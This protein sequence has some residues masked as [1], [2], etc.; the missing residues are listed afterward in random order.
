MDSLNSL[1][2]FVVSADTRS[3]AA[4]GRH[5]GISSSAVGKAIARLELRVSVR[6]FHRTTRS[7]TLTPEG[8]TLLE[9]CRRIFGEV[10]AAER[11][12]AQSVGA[13]RGRLRLS[14]P[15]VGRLLVP[16]LTEFAQKYPQ[17]ELELDFSDRVVD[18][19]DEGFDA[20]VRIGDARDSLLMTR[21]LGTFGHHVVAAPTYLEQH[22]LPASIDDLQNHRCLHHKFETTGKLAPWRFIVD[23]VE[24]QPELPRTI[25]ANTVEPLVHLAE[26]GLGL[27]YLPSYLIGSS[28]DTGRLVSVFDE[29]VKHRGMLRVLWPASQYVSPK[30]R[31]LVDFLSDH[32]THG[33]LD[34]TLSNS[35]GQ[36]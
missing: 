21:T 6:L 31:A 16:M 3:F 10:D 8:Q 24:T 26:Q 11:E 9:R 14:L 36:I 19:I 1:N 5:L 18:I 34:V 25:L 32:F 27:A 35:A 28:L 13:P 23:G 2:V 4:A 30:V 29:H 22:G 17:V 15:L 20:V 7:I 33:M 12:L